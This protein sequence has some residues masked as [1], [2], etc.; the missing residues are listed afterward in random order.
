MTLSTEDC[1]TAPST[2][3]SFTFSPATVTS[4]DSGWASPGPEKVTTWGPASTCC[5]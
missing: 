2:R 5:R 3:S 1:T 4:T